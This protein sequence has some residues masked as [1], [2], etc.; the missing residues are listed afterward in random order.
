MT[1][2]QISLIKETLYELECLE[3]EKY[4][5]FPPIDFEPSKNHIDKI[6]NIIESVAKKENSINKIPAKKKLIVLIAAAI[7]FTL[8][9]SA[10]AFGKQIKEFFVQFSD[11]LSQF[12]TEFDES[13]PFVVYE[14][15]YIP[16][17]YEVMQSKQHGR[18]VEVAYTNGDNIL[19]I[20]QKSANSSSLHIDTTETYELIEINKHEIHYIKKSKA[21]VLLWK[22]DNSSFMITS[23]DS[24]SWEEIE[25]VVIGIQKPTE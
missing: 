14:H 15:S 4:E 6:N 18:Y 25:K 10:C 19:V 11:V 13:L 8:I 9:F 20:I 21:Y 5:A 16:E 3:V 24:L 22:H 23:Q 7:I 2:S 12:S 1:K 17:G